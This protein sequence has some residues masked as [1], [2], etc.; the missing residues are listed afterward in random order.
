MPPRHF[1]SLQRRGENYGRT[2]SI[3]FG[4]IAALVILVSII[5]GIILPKFRKNKTNRYSGGLTP[6]VYSRNSP[7]FPSHPALLRGTRQKPTNTLRHYDPRIETPFQDGPTPL[8]TFNHGSAAL[9]QNH[10]ALTVG[11][12]NSSD[13][14][15]T[16]TRHYLPLQRGLQSRHDPDLQ[17]KRT[18][19]V[20]AT[21][22]YVPRMGLNGLEEYILPVPEPLVLRPRPA[23]RP[24]PLTRQLERFPMPIPRLSR[25][26]GLMHPGK[27]FSELDHCDSL[28]AAR[29]TLNTPCP[30][31]GSSSRLNGKELSFLEVTHSHPPSQDHQDAATV[32]GDLKPRLTETTSIRHDTNGRALAMEKGLV[33]ASTNPEDSQSLKRAGTVTRPKT[34][35]SEIRQWFDRTA[36]DSK[37][38]N[39]SFKRGWTPSSN[40]FTTPGPS[41]TPRTSPVLS[42]KTPSPILLPPLE[43]TDMDTVIDA[44]SAGPRSRRRT[45]SSAALPSPTKIAPLKPVESAKTASR[46][47]KKLCSTNVFARRTKAARPLNLVS[48]SRVQYRQ[49]HSLSSMSTVFKPMLGGTQSKQSY[50]ASSV[51]SRD[52]RGM[53][54][55]GSPGLDG[56]FND[57]GYPIGTAYSTEVP[58]DRQKGTS[59]RKAKAGS[60]DILRSKIDEWD[61]HT[62]DLDALTFTSPPPLLKRT[63]SDCGPRRSNA[64]D[65]RRPFVSSEDL[66]EKP[67]GLSPDAKPK[68]RVEHWDGDVWGDGLASIRDSILES[69]AQPGFSHQPALG[70][71]QD[72][73]PPP[74]SAPGGVDW[75]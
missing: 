64:F 34:P 3:I 26:G 61:L 59:R 63:Y 42:T 75:I 6:R 74:G 32:A 28:S 73:P 54:S 46:L 47:S 56:V 62:G 31:S 58:S 24:P 69:A 12:T 36:S 30:K 18:N 2:I 23:G 66:Q 27:V 33:T 1:Q 49:R 7:H 68:I 67:C 9:S 65:T 35:V 44:P 48:W 20:H 17:F 8:S 45:P 71:L 14:L 70:Q 51:Y 19:V 52:T 37:I 15:F 40:P 72:V 25:K 43:M 29:D 13:G 50:C 55:L 10:I 22:N 60:I 4:V 57:A 41:S 5:W 38:G 11:S 39:S 53:S 21:H 16:P